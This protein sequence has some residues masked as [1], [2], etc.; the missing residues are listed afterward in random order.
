MM[1]LSATRMKRY[2]LIGMC[3]YNESEPFSGKYATLS[4]YQRT[5]AASQ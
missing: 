5:I 4:D 1:D 3:W 2:G